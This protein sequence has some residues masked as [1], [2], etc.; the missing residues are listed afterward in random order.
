MLSELGSQIGFPADP[1]DQFKSETA[2]KRRMVLGVLESYNSNYAVLAE[3][4]QNAV[5]A[6]E[7]TIL[8]ALP[9][10]YEI[11]VHVDMYANKLSVRDSGIGMSREEAIW[12]FAPSVS[13]KHTETLRGTKRPYRGYK[14]VGLTFLAYGTDDIRLHSRHHVSGDFTTAK[15]QYGRSW[16]VGEQNE[17]A[18][19]VVDSEMSP[20]ENCERDTFISVQ[21]SPTTRPRRLNM[22]ASEPQ[23]WKV[24][25]QTRTAIGQIFL[26]DE[27]SSQITV[28]LTATDTEGQQHNFE[29]QPNFLL[30]HLVQRDPMFRFLD[31]PSY[32]AHNKESANIPPESQRQ[33][34]VYLV[35]N[36]E[37]IR[38]ELTDTQR[39][40]FEDELKYYTPVLYAFLP[41]NAVIWR[42]IN[43]QLT[44]VRNRRHLDSGLLLGINHQRLADA[45]DM[46][47]TRFETLSRNLFV[48][49][50]FDNAR[51]DQGRKTVQDDVLDLARK[52]ADRALQYLARQRDFLKPPGDA[53]TAEQRQV[54][55]NHD[56]WIFNVR[57]HA[58]TAPLHIPPIAY[59]SE[60][61]TEQDVIGL[62]N[63][64]AIVGVF[65][66]IRIFATSQ[67]RTYDSLVS[68]DCSTD[69]PGLQFKSSDSNPLGISPFIMG[70]K[71]KFST[72]Y[73][74]LEFK[75]NLDALISEV[76]SGSPKDFRHI[77][78]CVCWNQINENFKGFEI[79]DLTAKNIDE[80]RYPGSTNLLRKDGDAHVIQVIQLSKVVDMIRSGRIMLSSDL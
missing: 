32:Y 3:M 19:V 30:P 61:L 35:W 62:F 38:E 47:P 41:Y 23:V 40:D 57:S 31:L 13:F 60:P 50:H 59:Q 26:E 72:R 77:D 56:D 4:V 11:H 64:L 65:P 78:I 18:L 55:K 27:A 9:R 44:G 69:T 58:Q 34:G 33:D 80:R 43:E 46:S 75:N 71:E 45:F 66:G 48:L 53:P 42:Q 79:E 36:T 49:I 51:P 74:T 21:L 10:P 68:Y 20:L 8:L 73:L 63:Q 25:L 24:I 6:V 54:E 15:M 70:T 39:Q 7:D 76:E 22:I 16:A 52:T 29:V 37:R 28:H 12:A 17:S 1:L 2:Y 5:D 14:G 67:S